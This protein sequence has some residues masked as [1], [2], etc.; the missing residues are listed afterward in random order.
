MTESRATRLRSAPNF[1]EMEISTRRSI[2]RGPFCAVFG[3][4]FAEINFTANV[5]AFFATNTAVFNVVF[6]Y[7]AYTPSGAASGHTC[8]SAQLLVRCQVVDFLAPDSA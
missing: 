2:W 7:V 1:E 8:S 6:N 3:K 5:A 4:I